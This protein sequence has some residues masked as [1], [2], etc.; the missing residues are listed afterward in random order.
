VYDAERVR[1]RSIRD[2]DRERIEE[3]VIG[4]VVVGG[5]ILRRLR[6]RVTKGSRGGP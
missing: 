3:V 2:R 1:E 4:E 5:G 6:M